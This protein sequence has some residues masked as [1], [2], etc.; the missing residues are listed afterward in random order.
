M[1][2]KFIQSRI[3]ANACFLTYD[4]S[5]VTK[6][7]SPALICVCHIV[8]LFLIFA[9]RKDCHGARAAA[10]VQSPCL[11]L[12]S[13]VIKSWIRWL[14]WLIVLMR[15][16][17]TW[18]RIPSY[19]C[20]AFLDGLTMWE[21]PLEI[22][23]TAPQTRVWDWMKWAKEIEPQHFCPCVTCKLLSCGFSGIM[24]FN[25]QIK[26]DSLS[27]MLPVPWYLFQKGGM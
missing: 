11:S 9:L 4:Y 18:R 16:N 12:Q 23:Q 24:P 21:D 5:I 17:I 2:L 27:L 26:T 13:A 1:Y 22:W 20:E 6:C 10:Y 25:M 19:E 14:L 8:L 7:V 3:S 15:L